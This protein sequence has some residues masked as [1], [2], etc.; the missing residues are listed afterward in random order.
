MSSHKTFK[1][2]Q[3]LAKKQK[4][5]RPIPQWIQMKTGNKARYN[6]KRKHW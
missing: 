5:N 6:S 2:K 3:F 4:Q 1:I